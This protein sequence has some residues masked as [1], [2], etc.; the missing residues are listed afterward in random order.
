[1]IVL[2]Y[3]VLSYLSIQTR[4]QGHG[5]PGEFLLQVHM[6]LKIKEV[7]SQ[8]YT[9]SIRSLLLFT[10]KGGLEKAITALFQHYIK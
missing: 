9:D 5:D 6:G 2:T 7:G 10:E 8:F 4:M 1:M 3:F